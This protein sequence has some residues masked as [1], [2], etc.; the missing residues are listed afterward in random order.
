MS[1][2]AITSDWVGRVID[3][4]FALLEWL[5]GTGNSGVFRTEL[6][7]PIM[8]KA[9]IKL[10][11]AE[12]SAADSY[13]SG[14]AKAANLSHP[15]LMRVFRSGRFQFGSLG[16][17]YVVTECADE[18]LS[19]II[20]ER[21]LT[22]EETREM[23]DPVIEALAYLH[24]KGFVH[25][26]LKPSNILAM[27]DKLKLSGDSVAATGGVRVLKRPA[28][29][30]DAP[31]AARGV[32]APSLDVWALGAT[33]VEVLT[34]RTPVWER[35]TSQEPMVPATLPRPFAEIARE[36]LRREP[37]RRPTL[38]E[39][40]ARIEPIPPIQF[41]ASKTEKL[42]EMA[43]T[44][45]AES[46]PETDDAGSGSSSKM[47]VLALVAGLVVVVILMAVWMTR[48]HAPMPRT[49]EG[50][51]QS[52]AQSATAPDSSSTESVATGAVAE[53]ALPEVTSGAR[54]TIHG[55]IVVPVRVTVD[56]NGRVTHAELKSGEKSRYFSRV[57]MEAARGWKFKAA[58]KS[59][60]PVNS[61]WLLRFRF[62]QSGTEA[63]AVEETP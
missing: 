36:C 31:E 56:A 32:I 4:R 3:A 23:L 20:P 47:R 30:Y 27:D 1:G 61:V 45:V 57:A 15:H 21:A 59:G 16:L 53:R 51:V 19:Q 25:G 28:S 24:G 7:Q 60:Q 54:R 34:Q 11:A 52:S 49:E 10:I 62:R 38:S 50:G 48:K 63:E 12:G 55:T 43:E 44:K 18:V 40:R 29:I 46:L 22:P 33:L 9:A 17:V 5:G 6:P 42:Q 14:W 26:H 58:Q 37:D 39:I 8:K 35:T 13:L 41:P 2:P